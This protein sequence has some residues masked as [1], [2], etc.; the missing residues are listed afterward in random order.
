MKKPRKQP[1]PRPAKLT[2][3]ERRQQLA[4]HAIT[5][6]ATID[7]TYK[8]AVIKRA[9]PLLTPE[10][11]ELI[12]N[13]GDGETLQTL[14][15][16]LLSHDAMAILLAV[17]KFSEYVSDSTR[18]ALGIPPDVARRHP[19]MLTRHALGRQRA[20]A[21][22]DLGG[23][24]ISEAAAVK[25]VSRIIDAAIGFGLIQEIVIR[26]NRK[27]LRATPVLDDI[28]DDVAKALKPVFKK[29]LRY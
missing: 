14:F 16:R 15:S 27:L 3:R 25:S 7:L 18:A 9:R 24:S 12:E 28:F 19:G 1:A 5:L 21:M 2:A 6:S 4:A 23:R 26:P 22:D 17:W 11:V 10:A 29:L 20:S 13:L 8:A